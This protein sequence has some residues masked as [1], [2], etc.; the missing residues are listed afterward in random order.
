MKKY[1]VELRATKDVEVEAESALEAVKIA[2]EQNPEY[3]AESAYDGETLS[4]IDTCNGCG[5]D[6][7]EEDYGG[8]DT[9]GNSYC[10]ECHSAS[11]QEYLAWIHD[12]TTLGYGRGFMLSTEHNE[13]IDELYGDK[14]PAEAL[15]YLIENNMVTIITP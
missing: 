8:N 7:L 5:V 14:E 12:L 2:K 15:E 13:E 6:M 10:K 11:Q 4:L 3:H 9:D 1:T